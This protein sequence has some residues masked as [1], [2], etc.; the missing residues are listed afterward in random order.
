MEASLAPAFNHFDQTP[1]VTDEL[2]LED[3]TSTID[4]NMD[5]EQ[6]S[7]EESGETAISPLEPQQMA[8]RLQQCS[9]NALQPDANLSYVSSPSGTPENDHSPNIASVLSASSTFP[10]FG[11][12][13]DR[14]KVY[15]ETQAR[16][17]IKTMMEQ[18][19][20]G[21]VMSNL[22]MKFQQKSSNSFSGTPSGDISLDKALEGADRPRLA[23]KTST[24][25]AVA[26]EKTKERFPC[27]KCAKT[28]QR[29]CELRY[30]KKSNFSLLFFTLQTRT[31][32][33]IGI[34]ENMLSGTRNHTDASIQSA[35]LSLGARTTESG[36][37]IACTCT[38]NLSC[39]VS[40]VRKAR[41]RIV[42]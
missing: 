20:L 28:F 34:I 24:R 2:V 27:D 25:S 26:G 21:K 37:R 12:E 39:V 19:I 3:P 36:T 16:E 5:D 11:K 14:T 7:I 22:G 1:Q 35:N 17:I 15:D 29:M 32:G 23:Q 4:T 41:R 42:T 6:P 8:E 33:Q 13:K 38:R 10:S 30:G 9:M 18:G 40:S 31:D